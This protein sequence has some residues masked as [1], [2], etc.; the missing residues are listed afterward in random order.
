MTSSGDISDDDVVWHGF[1]FNVSDPPA[2]VAANQRFL[3]T[4]TGKRFPGQ[5][6][7]VA[8]VAAGDSSTT[9]S[10]IVGYESM[11]EME[12]WNE[13]L[14]G[15]SEWAAYLAQVERSADLQ[16]SNL[17]QTLGAWGRSMKE[18]VGR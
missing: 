8:T 10:I 14:A 18:V 5:V 15:N 7:V 17:S 13:S 4:D 16:G 1:D 12:T 9:H 6:H 11:A 2:F 3:L